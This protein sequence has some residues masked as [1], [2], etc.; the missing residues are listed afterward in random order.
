MQPGAAKHPHVIPRLDRGINCR[1]IR[2]MRE[3]HVYILANS[4]RGTLYIGVTGDLERRMAEH[5]GMVTD[6]FTRRYGV[7]RLV[8]VE[9]FAHPEDAI[10]REKRLKKWPRD[11]KIK[12][13]EAT[14]PEW[15]DLAAG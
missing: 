13:V 6:S 11:W 14:N 3:Y 12:L 8:H 5:R 7:I 1:S 4:K 10:R 9:A 2:A 15:M